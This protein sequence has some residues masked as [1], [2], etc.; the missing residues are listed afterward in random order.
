MH[1]RDGCVTATPNLNCNSTEGDNCGNH[2]LICQPGPRCHTIAK[3]APLVLRECP[4]ARAGLK[5]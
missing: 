1:R 5:S 3:H 4:A 2:A